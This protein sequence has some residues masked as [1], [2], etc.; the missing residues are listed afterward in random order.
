ME[1]AIKNIIGRDVSLDGLYEENR[2]MIEDKSSPV[3][4]ALR[5]EAFKAFQK[6]GIPS[7]KV[8]DYKYTNL[9]PLFTGD[10]TF[11]LSPGTL[12]ENLED[13]FT[14][15][16]DELDS[17]TIFMV[18]GWYYTRNKPEGLPEGVRVGSLAQ[19]AKD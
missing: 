4:N 12:T 8:E 18:N 17:F 14:C 15:D 3:L 19:L 16:V 1:N 11:S 9:Q 10:Y 13:V 2:S 6:L 5:S 7:K